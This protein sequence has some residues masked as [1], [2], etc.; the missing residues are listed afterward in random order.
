M[1]QI[2]RILFPTDFSEC[3]ERAYTHAALLS[4][5]H[6]SELHVLNVLPPHVVPANNPMA[7][8]K[9]TAAGCELLEIAAPAPAPASHTTAAMTAFVPPSGAEAPPTVYSQ[10][11]SPS[12]TKGILDYGRAH[13]IDLIVMGTHGRQ[14]I[15]HLMLGSVAEDV[16]RN[17]S[18][19]VLTIRFDET[20]P[21]E[22][23]VRRI[24]VPID[25]S[26]FSTL[27][28]AVELARTYGAELDMLH[29]IEESVLPTIYGV[30][31]LSPNAPLYV[32]R[33]EGALRKLLD[34]TCASD[35]TARQHVRIGHPPRRILEF[36]DERR[37]D[38]I[39]L[40]SHGR[41]G[42]SRLLIGSVAEKV[43]RLA[44][45]PVF[46]VKSYGK[47]L[48]AQDGG[49]LARQEGAGSALNAASANGA[50]GSAARLAAG[51]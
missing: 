4:A 2:R 24:L 15:D 7:F 44:P 5:R 51:V 34:A 33:T 8:L 40:G 17:A 19:S 37:A 26:E 21:P 43:V 35:I 22:T 11:L 23:A 50:I 14:G 18:R 9:E 12:I 6:G 16:V 36:A 28:V 10:L 39:V 30:E 27:D 29:V 45:C 1:L 42:L 38:L 25:F 20:T 31:P 47:P 41:T 3:A 49:E 13:D 32:E 48:L 46:T